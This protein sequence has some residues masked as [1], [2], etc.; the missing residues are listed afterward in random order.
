VRAVMLE[1]AAVAQAVGYPDVSDEKVEWQ[2]D[3]AKARSLPGIEPSMMA[4]ALAGR[5]MEADA[6][7][8][9]AIRIA[10]TKGVKVPLLKA[11]FALLKALNES[12]KREQAKE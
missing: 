1:I 10:D 12:Y 9:N 5:E 3:R 2:M 4:D 8:G 7:V 6:I 11:N